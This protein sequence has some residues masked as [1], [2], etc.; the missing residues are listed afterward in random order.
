MAPRKDGVQYAGERR[1]FYVAPGTDHPPARGIQ[2]PVR[3]PRLPSLRPGRRH[4]RGPRQSPQAA[5]TRCR[6]W[7]GKP[8]VTQIMIAAPANERRENM[9]RLMPLSILGFFFEAN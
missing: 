1:A 7:P 6:D 2:A 5:D 9:R 3:H 8:Q 4:R